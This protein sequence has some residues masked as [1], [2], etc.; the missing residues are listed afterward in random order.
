MRWESLLVALAAH[1]WQTVGPPKVIETHDDPELSCNC[2]CSCEI[3]RS[4][5]FEGLVGLVI[6]CSIGWSFCARA[7]RPQTQP[8]TESPSTRRRRGHG[9]LVTSDSREAVGDLLQ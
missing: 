4:W 3:Q 2:A 6:V 7:S 8:L 9:V 5:Y 1:L